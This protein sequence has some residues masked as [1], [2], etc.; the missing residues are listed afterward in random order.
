MIII[1]II[2]M[3]MNH[4]HNNR[5]NDDNANNPKVGAR[6]GTLAASPRPDNVPLGII[7]L[8]EDV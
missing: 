7:I 5:N 2:L 4:T 6:R 3:I 8:F 1:M